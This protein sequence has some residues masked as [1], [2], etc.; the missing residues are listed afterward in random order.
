MRV[1]KRD[2]KG[3][4]RDFDGKSEKC[5]RE[6][7]RGKGGYLCFVLGWVNIAFSSLLRILLFFNPPS[8]EDGMDDFRIPM[9]SSPSIEVRKP[10]TPIDK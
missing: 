6:K 7:E 4:R 10:Y 9:V 1:K 5:I 3:W 2:L 8:T